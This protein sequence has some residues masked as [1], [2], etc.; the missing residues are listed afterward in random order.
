[1]TGP[2]TPKVLKGQIVVHFENL[3]VKINDNVPGYPPFSNDGLTPGQN[4][5]VLATFMYR[6]QDAGT[7]P[8]FLVAGDGGR[9][10]EIAATRCTVVKAKGVSA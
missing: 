9:I 8:C 6:F 7:T 3:V 4:Y 10:V 1:M 5:V 2:K